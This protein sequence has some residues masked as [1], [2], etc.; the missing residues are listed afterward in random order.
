MSDSPVA[1]SKR[2]AGVILAELATLKTQREPI[3]DAFTAAQR[4]CRE[5]R[6]EGGAKYAAAKRELAERSAKLTEMRERKSALA[7]ELDAAYS[8]KSREG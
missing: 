2:D 4:A 5:H 8:R 1:P 3:V 6:S 7:D